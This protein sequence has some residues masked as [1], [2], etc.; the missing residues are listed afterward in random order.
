VHGLGLRNVCNY[1]A[2]P[3]THLVSLESSSM[4]KGARTWFERMFGAM[5][6]KAIDY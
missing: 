2:K 1:G 6:Q 4:R 3:T 5:V